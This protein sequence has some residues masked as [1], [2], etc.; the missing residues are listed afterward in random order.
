MQEITCVSQVLKLFNQWVDVP[1]KE[2]YSARTNKQETNEGI[3]KGNL[4]KFH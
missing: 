1:N 3:E 2:I 4:E